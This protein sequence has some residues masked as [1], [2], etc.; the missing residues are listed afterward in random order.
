MFNRNA[1]WLGLLLGLAIPFVGY[2][3]LL[4]LF[5]QLDAA[6]LL[7]SKGFSANFRQRTLTI[8]ALCLNV[9]PF[10]YFYKRRHLHSMRG[11]AIVT[12]LY[13]V[14]W[15]IYYGNELLG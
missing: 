13:A 8:V 9:I 10:N 14:A 4:T 1:I 11:I 5:E 6:G 15:V 7:S 3:L 12:V 2:A